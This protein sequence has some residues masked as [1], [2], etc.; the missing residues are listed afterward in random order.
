MSDEALIE[1]AKCGDQDAFTELY[2]RY[3]PIVERKVKYILRRHPLAVEDVT[4][5]VMSSVMLHLH[6]FDGRSQLATWIHRIAINKSLMYLRSKQGK[7]SEQTIPLE[8]EV[9]PGVFVEHLTVADGG[10]RRVDASM[11]IDKALNGVSPLLAYSLR[12]RY[13]DGL[14][15][16]EVADET[17]VSVAAVKSQL[18]R[19]LLTAREVLEEAYV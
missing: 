16:K 17:A 11:D 7:R 8:M 13:I 18:H 14:S 12:R 15:N 3:Q 19:G 10:Y 2:R 4:A 9:E 6:G 1:K 5:A